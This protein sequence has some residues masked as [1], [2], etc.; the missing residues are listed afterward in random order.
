MQTCN[1]KYEISA[2]FDPSSEKNE[3]NRLF[4][5]IADHLKTCVFAISD[6]AVFSN[7]DRGSILRRLLRRAM[8]C[9]NKLG[10]DK[11][12]ITLT[13]NSIINVYSS[14]FPKLS[15]SQQQINEILEKERKLFETTIEKG[16]KL[17]QK[18]TFGKKTMDA[19][20]IFK[21]MDT[22]GFP[23]EI[24]KELCEQN[25]ISFNQEAYFSLVE[26]HRKI[27][28]A[29]VENK[30]M[31]VQSPDLINFVAD[32]E[33]VYDNFFLPKSKIIALFDEKFSLCDKACNKC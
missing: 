22:Y 10:C 18:E 2:Y 31:S 23:Y 17:F 4:R 3:V 24:I 12:F 26:K 11:T 6:G 19:E 15:Y 25:S 1:K 28:K 27:S 5:I 33:F 21:L 29:N 20:V 30:G 7:K 9:A 14:F 8:V 32:S 16:I 13:A